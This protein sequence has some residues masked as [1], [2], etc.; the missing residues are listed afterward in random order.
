[1]GPDLLGNFDKNWSMTRENAEVILSRY[2]RETKGDLIT[3][4]YSKQ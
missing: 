3:F 2:G 1:M 4:D